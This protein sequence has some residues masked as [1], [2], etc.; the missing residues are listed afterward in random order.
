MYYVS[1]EVPSGLFIG[2]DASV[3]YFSRSFAQFV[4]AGSVPGKSIYET[5]TA[6]AGSDL[7]TFLT[8]GSNAAAAFPF[9]GN[10]YYIDSAFYDRFSEISSV[11]LL[12]SKNVVSSIINTSATNNIGK[13]N[14]YPNPATAGS[15]TV[16]VAL[17][18]KSS[19]VV[20]RLT[21]L[22]GRT[23]Y[24]EVHNDVLNEKYEI[25]TAKYATGTYYLMIIT[26]NGFDNKKI[27]IQN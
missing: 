20:Y 17:N 6:M 9:S 23:L 4:N 27:S 26:D 16:D 15:V 11:A 25:N 18:Q 13:S 22:I 10:A 5:P 3:N 2:V 14:I 8:T 19:K 21:D 7:S 24:T 12:M 1:V